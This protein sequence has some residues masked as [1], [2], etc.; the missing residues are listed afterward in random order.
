MHDASARS[1]NSIATA[2]EPLGRDDMLTHPPPSDSIWA[3]GCVV[4][5]PGRDDQPRYLMV[6]R[7]AYGDWTLPKGKLDPGETFLEGAVRETFEETGFKAENPRLIGTIA[8][9]TSNENPKVV[10][11]WLGQAAGGKFAPNSEVDRVKWV[12]FTK[13]QNWLTY[14]NDREVLDRANDMQLDRSAGIVYLVRH[15]WAGHRARVT[16]DDWS[17]PL[18]ERGLRQRDALVQVLQ[19][20]PLTR[21]GSSDY[22]RCI[23]TVRPLSE[24]MGIPLESETALVEGSHPHRLVALI[25]ELQGEAAVLCTHGDVISNLVGH[26]FASG[27]P[28]DGEMTWKKGSIWELRTL[29]GRVVS[30][31]YVPPPA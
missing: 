13:G 24:R 21:I 12:R 31:R 26:L 7:P 8:Y 16:N 11:W 10:R 6:H 22:T 18:D 30:G 19:A 14:R 2:D 27:I 28:M 5:R 15:G 23:Q 25:H 20:H 1:S 17:R 29:E 4:T 3:A 9:D